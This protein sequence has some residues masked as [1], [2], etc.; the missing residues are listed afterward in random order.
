VIRPRR[1]ELA[2]AKSRLVEG[3]SPS[4]QAFPGTVVYTTEN[5]IRC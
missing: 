3:I 4:H 1:V 2:R 5:G